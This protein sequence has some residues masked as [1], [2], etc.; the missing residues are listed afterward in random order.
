MPFVFEDGAWKIDIAGE[1]ASIEAEVEEQN[2]K[3]DDP[4]GFS[5]PLPAVTQEQ[6]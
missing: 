5:N 1:A 2:R 6:P 3:F 4:S